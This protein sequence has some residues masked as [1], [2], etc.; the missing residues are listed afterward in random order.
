ME[1]RFL[2]ATP[3]APHPKTKHKDQG[4]FVSGHTQGHS[5]LLSPS[6]HPRVNPSRATAA[7]AG[8]FVYF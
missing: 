3:S 6:E 1:A 4:F 7:C 8:A 2:T 5:P